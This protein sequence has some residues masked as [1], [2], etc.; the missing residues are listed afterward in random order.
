MHP[1]DFEP[2]LETVDVFKVAQYWQTPFTRFDFSIRKY[3][4]EEA[5]LEGKRH[6][7]SDAFASF[8][9]TVDGETFSKLCIELL[10]AED[11]AI[12]TEVEFA[13]D[14]AFD[15]VGNVLLLEPAGF[16]RFEKW[17]FEFK[18]YR[19]NRVSARNLRQIEAILDAGNDQF[20]IICLVTSGDLTS[21]GNHIAVKN[22]RIRVWDR[23][24]LQ[25]LVNK[26][27]NILKTYF[28]EYKVAVDKLSQQYE[29]DISVEVDA[30]SIPSR[31]EEFKLKLDGCPPGKEHSTIYENLGV[32]LWQYLYPT[33]L[34]KPNPQSRTID[35]KQR[36]DV[37]FRNQ[38]IG[39]F[40][41]RIAD[42]FGS[43]FVIID[44][45]NYSEPV[46]SNVIND[47]TKY[48]NK[49]IGRFIIIMSRFG[50]DDTADATQIRL[51]RDTNTLVLAISDKQMLE[52]IVR[53]EKGENP[54][55]VIEDIMDELLL[56]Y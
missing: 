35:G 56:Q 20:D 2:P 27:L 12:Q 52:M 42:K 4:A 7:L 30:D 13:K 44:F 41:Q 29:A 55:D 34:G 51:L 39:R 21:V 24:I 3:G 6:A 8:W 17:I 33:K 40:F 46:N 11:I 10:E 5:E 15:A 53:R 48:A 9:Q 1:Q 54:E 22:S 45:K 25:Y 49:A 14:R 28:V 50:V 26:H 37:L 43:D 36:R 31:L 32:E 38:R 23:N 47:V 18:H 16:R 19:E